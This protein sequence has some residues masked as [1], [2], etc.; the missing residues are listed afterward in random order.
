[1]ADVKAG[2][3]RQTRPCKAMASLKLTAMDRANGPVPIPRKSSNG[4]GVAPKCGI[5]RQVHM[6]QSLAS[7][8]S[9]RDCS[10]TLEV[11]RAKSKSS[12]ASHALL[13]S[14]IAW[15]GHDLGDLFLPM[16]GAPI[17]GGGVQHPEAF[18][19]RISARRPG[20]PKAS[21]RTLRARPVAQGGAPGLR[22]E[23]EAT[24]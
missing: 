14:A 18:T 11:I 16:Q 4:T 19:G 15:R 22:S 8:P 3:K 20:R 17:G 21:V 10:G 12:K 24:M 5:G 23:R 6:R 1:M 2:R 9:F 7:R 13:E